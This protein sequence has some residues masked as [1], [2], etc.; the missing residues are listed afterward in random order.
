[1]E[2]DISSEIAKTWAITK[3]DY[4]NII[5]DVMCDCVLLDGGLS[6]LT[7]LFWIVKVIYTPQGSGL[8]LSSPLRRNANNSNVNIKIVEVP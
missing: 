6:D 7:A 3:L 1:M 8:T 5:G 2:Y 4:K